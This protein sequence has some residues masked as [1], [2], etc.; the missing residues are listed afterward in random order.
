MIARG[1]TNGEVTSMTRR[2]WT[3]RPSAPRGSLSRAQEGTLSS[4]ASS[5][6]EQWVRAPRP[7][8][9]PDHPEVPCGDQGAVA[10][11]TPHDRAVK[12]LDLAEWRA[13]AQEARERG[14]LH[15]RR[16]NKARHARAR[17][18]RRTA[19]HEKANADE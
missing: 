15:A 14:D 12:A 16:V 8:G 1:V 17:R 5:H 7:P 9:C 18:A 19:N 13:D 11:Q 4:N 3:V 10:E 6:R 2:G